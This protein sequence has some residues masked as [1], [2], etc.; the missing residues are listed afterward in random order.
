MK[1]LIML[2]IK[3]ITL[4]FLLNFGDTIDSKDNEEGMQSLDISV[5]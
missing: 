3:A 5:S 1:E 2:L 4:R